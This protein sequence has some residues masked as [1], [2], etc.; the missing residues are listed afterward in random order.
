VELVRDPVEPVDDH[1]GHPREELDQGHAWVGDV[2]LGPLRARL[3][4]PFPGLVDEILE[5]PVVEHDFR[6]VHGDSSAGMR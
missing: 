1:L 2:V 5:A 6:Q 4:D 3:R